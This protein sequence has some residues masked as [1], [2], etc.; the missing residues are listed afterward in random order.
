MTN[1]VANLDTEMV[2]SLY[3]KYPN[4]EL[5]TDGE[6]VGLPKGQMGNS[7][8]GHLNIGAGRIVHQDLLKINFA[9]NNNSIAEMENC[10]NV[11]KYVKQKNTDLHFI[12]LV[13]DGGVHSHQNHLYK[14]CELA[15][16]SGVQNVFVHAFTDGRDCDPKSGKEFIEKLEEN[17]FG[18]KIASICGRYYAAEIY[19]GDA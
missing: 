14:L 2:D 1:A 7:E 6:N 13:S 12:G 4:C 10:Q 18:E 3:D 15:H 5:L 19:V 11:F 17:L 8:V 16:I 9:C